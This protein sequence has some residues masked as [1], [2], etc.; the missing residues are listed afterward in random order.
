MRT[1]LD[2]DGDVLQ[3]AKELAELHKKTTG[4]MVSELLRRALQ[5]PDSTP[6]VRNGVRLFTPRPGMPPIT[7]AM[8]NQW[9]DED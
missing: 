8:V 2:I 1:T 5:P 4:Q 3:A 6:K 7:M 9:R